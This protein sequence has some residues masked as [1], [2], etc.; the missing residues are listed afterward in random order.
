M[1]TVL[2]VDDIAG[3]C[4]LLESLLTP[5]G[6]VVRTASD[7]DEAVRAV[8][9]APPD[10]VLLDVMMPHVDGFEACRAIK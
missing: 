4:R 7:G 2:V 6:H 5:D 3:N 10:L 8:H 9:D 1:G